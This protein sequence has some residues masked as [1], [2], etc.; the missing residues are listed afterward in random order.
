MEVTYRPAR[1]RR[2][3]PCKPREE[4]YVITLST[5]EY[6]SLS[7]VVEMSPGNLLTIQENA[8]ANDFIVAADD[9]LES[10]QQ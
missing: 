5:E 9:L 3:W 10:R 2:G 7:S 8:L 4:Q 6:E 1:M